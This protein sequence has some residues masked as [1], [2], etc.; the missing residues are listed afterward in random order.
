MASPRAK[1]MQAA[2][3]HGPGAVTC[4]QNS[5]KRS[6]REFGGLPAMIAAL[7]APIDFPAIQVRMDGPLAQC[8]IDTGLIGAK[9]TAALQHQSDNFEGKMICRRCH[10]RLNLSMRGTYVLRSG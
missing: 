9:C 6:T 7:M 4:I 5:R 3:N 2:P 8:L 10:I 1:P